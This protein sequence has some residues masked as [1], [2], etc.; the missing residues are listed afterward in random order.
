MPAKFIVYNDKKGK[1]RFNLKAVNGEII[2]TGKS[3][4][5]KKACLK[6]IASIVKNAPIAAVVDTTAE[7]KEPKEKSIAKHISKEKI[8]ETACVG[9]TSPKYTLSYCIC[10][11]NKI[12][13]YIDILNGYKVKV[14]TILDCFHPI[15]FAKIKEGDTVIDLGCGDG[16]DCSISSSITGKTGRIIGID[17]SSNMIE[18]ARYNVNRLRLTNVEFINGNIE[19]IPLEANI[20]DVVISNCAINMAR[21]IQAVIKEIYRILKPNGHFSIINAVTLKDLHKKNKSDTLMYDDRLSG[22][23][24]KELFLEYIKEAGFKKITT[25]HKE[26]ID[27][28]DKIQNENCQTEKLLLFSKKPQG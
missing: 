28:P 3:Y 18:T 14:A 12:R 22:P 9:N 17:N 23:I 10:P 19:H 27:L 8:R 26:C 2:V 7:K 15:L 13:Q 24:E 20:A 21:N 4:P 11:H 5:D 6:G 1:Y 25:K 16:R